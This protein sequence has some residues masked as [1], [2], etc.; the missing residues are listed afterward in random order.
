MNYSLDTLITQFNSADE[1]GK[2]KIN[3]ILWQVVPFNRPHQIEVT[4]WNKNTISAV[5]PLIKDNFNHLQ[6]IHACGLATVSEY[7][8]G[9]LLLS[10][11]GIEKYRLIMA[12]LE[13]DYTYQARTNCTANFSLTDNELS[14]IKNKAE[15]EDKFIFPA[16]VDVKDE[17]NNIVCKATIYWQIK[18][19]DKVKLK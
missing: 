6:G 18:S 17:N 5:I 11:L 3:E 12:K 8:T 7:V 1:N 16:Q 19:W 2:K 4:Q 9:L 13:V 14:T 10:N 15:N